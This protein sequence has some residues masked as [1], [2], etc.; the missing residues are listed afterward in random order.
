MFIT[1]TEI[2]RRPNFCMLPYFCETVIWRT[3]VTWSLHHLC[4]PLSCRA[5]VAL[6]VNTSLTTTA[7][8]T[9][10]TAA[11]HLSSSHSHAWILTCTDWDCLIRHIFKSSSLK[12]KYTFFKMQRKTSDLMWF[13]HFLLSPMSQ[14]WFAVEQSFT[15]TGRW[16]LFSH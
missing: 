7:P 16:S 14:K 2:W 5:E 15:H 6:G 13:L 12:T 11:L 4:V 9:S 10:I 3:A 1:V 8:N